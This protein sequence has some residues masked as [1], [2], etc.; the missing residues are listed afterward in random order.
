MN[1]PVYKEII[2]PKMLFFNS[3]N[4][5]SKGKCQMQCGPGKLSRYSD[6]LRTGRSGNQIPVGDDIF[7]TRLDRPCDPPY[8][9]YNRCRV[10]FPGV[11]RSDLGVDHLPHLAPNLKKEYSNTSTPPLGLHDLFQGKIY[12]FRCCGT[13][14]Y[15][16]LLQILFMCCF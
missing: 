2:S 3:S 16:A 8:L 6:S 5:N 1:N 13:R 9:L 15:C 7:R 11:K 14:K 4:S 10:S 12:I